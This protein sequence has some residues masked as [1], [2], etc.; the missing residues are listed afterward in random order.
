[1]DLTKYDLVPASN[2]GRFLHLFTPLGEKLLTEDGEPIGLTVKGADSDD[3]KLREKKRD[4]ARL[5]KVR[6]KRNG[7]IS[8]LGGAEEDQRE[9]HASAVVQYHNIVVDGEQWTM[10]PSVEQTSKLFRRFSW[11]ERQVIEFIQDE[12]NWLGES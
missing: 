7:A 6:V 1:M 9:L 5:E 10:A 8:G 11:I 12:E 4:A 3:Y 2:E